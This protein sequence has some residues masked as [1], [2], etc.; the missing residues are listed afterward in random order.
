MLEYRFDQPRTFDTTSQ[1]YVRENLR[2]PRAA[3]VYVKLKTANWAAQHPRVPL[4]PS[5]PSSNASAK[6]HM[7]SQ[8][9]MPHW[10]NV[11]HSLLQGPCL[12]HD[13]MSHVELNWLSPTYCPE[14][15]MD[16][17]A[18]PDGI[19]TFTGALLAMIFPLSAVQRKLG[20]SSSQSGIPC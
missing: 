10:Q 7:D 3:C 4:G 8:F 6:P 1:H 5:Q 17:A 19:R 9:K 16:S 2:S 20:C 14:V 18:T 15:G 11:L 13:L 12:N